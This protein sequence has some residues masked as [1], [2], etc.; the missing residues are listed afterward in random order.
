MCKTPVERFG[1]RWTGGMNHHLS[2]CGPR[3]AIPSLDT[4][5]R[6]GYWDSPEAAI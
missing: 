4:A 3:L 6:V 1:R 5:A 2:R